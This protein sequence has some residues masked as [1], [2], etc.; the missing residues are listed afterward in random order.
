LTEFTEHPL[1]YLP[2]CALGVLPEDEA[3]I[4]R[5]HVKQCDDCR[6]EYDEMARVAQMLP[7]AAED[8]APS[9][10]VKDG[11]LE[12]IA[13]E[14]RALPGRIIRPRWAWAGSVAAGA[15]ALLVAGGVLGA[16]LWGGVTDGDDSDRQATLVQSV[17]EGT[18][19]RDTVESNGVEAVFVHAPGARDGFAWVEGLPVLADGKAYQAWFIREGRAEPS[20]VFRD[21]TGVWMRAGSGID[22]YSAMGLTIE[23]EDGADTP[24][25]APFVVVNLRDAASRR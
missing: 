18:V 17:A 12:R 9:P 7:M 16:T 20:A 21:G 25:S 15:A 24:S 3:S 14:P 1:D 19:A 13:S 6:A 5:A 23:D 2:E 8:R 10:A 11:L 4:V 22:D